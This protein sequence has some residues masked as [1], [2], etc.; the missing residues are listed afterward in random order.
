M[1]ASPSP[2]VKALNDQS[3]AFV[4]IPISLESRVSAASR[5]KVQ[6]SLSFHNSEPLIE[7]GYLC[8]C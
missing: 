2:A 1:V 5:N 7:P 6:S 3:P 4:T 8:V